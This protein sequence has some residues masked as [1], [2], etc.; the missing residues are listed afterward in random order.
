ML[1]S[2]PSPAAWGDVVLDVVRHRASA[3]PRLDAMLAQRPDFVPG[4]CLKGFG[5]LFTGR[6]ALRE[7]ARTW[8]GRARRAL[9]TDP[10]SPNRHLVAAL[11]AWIDDDGWAADAALERL[12]REAPEDLFALKVQHGLLFVMGQSAAMRDRLEARTEAWPHDHPHRRYVV[13]CLMFARVETGDLGAAREAWA[14][15][16]EPADDPWGLHAVAHLLHES[17]DVEAALGWLQRRREQWAPC[18]RFGNH[19]DWHRALLQLRLGAPEAALQIFDERLRGVF[20]GN[21][22]D[23]SNAV[24]ILWRLEVR[25]VDVGERWRELAHA[26]RAFLDDHGSAFADAHYLLAQL[27]GGCSEGVRRLLDSLTATTPPDGYQARV[28]ATVGAP[29]CQALARWRSEPAAARAELRALAPDLARIG[30][31]H[32]QRSLFDDVLAYLETGTRGR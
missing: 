32:A 4:L 31:S 15:W 24:S 29:L 5:L 21:Y 28:V 18:D 10:E 2:S 19:L 30:G 16:G 26:S 13:G 14:S 17:G 27:H 25:G 23:M 8:S 12:L 3:G 22:R 1:A 7:E 11:D 20:D 6:R 9:L